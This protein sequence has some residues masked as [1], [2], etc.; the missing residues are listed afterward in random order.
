MGYLDSSG[1][2]RLWNKI[3]SYVTNHHIDVKTSQWNNTGTTT[4]TLG[5]KFSGVSGIG[6]LDEY[7]HVT[8]QVKAPEFILPNV[9]CGTFNVSGSSSTGSA[10][11]TFLKLKHIPKII[12]V[13]SLMDDTY[14]NAELC[15]VWYDGNLISS[16]AGSIS[17]VTSTGFSFV[18]LPGKHYWEAWG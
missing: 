7:G 18:G 6:A 2:S 11:A 15:C 17:N 16:V 9:E 14:H 3:K 13:Q 5:D 10:R 12:K 8:T 4:L 1:L